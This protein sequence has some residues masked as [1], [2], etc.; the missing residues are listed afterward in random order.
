MR[1]EIVGTC[2]KYWWEP[3]EGKAAEPVGH[4]K[5]VCVFQ[6]IFMNGSDELYLDFLIPASV[7]TSD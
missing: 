2:Q 5:A 6:G 7:P 3:K 1:T 4:E